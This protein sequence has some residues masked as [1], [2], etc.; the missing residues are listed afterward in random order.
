MASVVVVVASSEV[1]R[2]TLDEH[3]D[4]DD[5]LHVVIPAV[6]QSRLQWLTNDEGAA[7]ERA[8]E[9]GDEIVQEA[10]V[11]DASVDVKRDVPSQAVL[12]AI[13]E[14]DPDRIVVVLRTGEDATWLEEGELAQV[15]GEIAGVPVVRVSI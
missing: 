3:I 10:P 1:D 4:P 6:E 2:T 5:E 14:H 12:D 11:L 7:R 9:V 15:P 8:R 13:A